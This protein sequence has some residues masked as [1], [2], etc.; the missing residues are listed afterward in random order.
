[1]MSDITNRLR[2]KYPLGP[3]GEDGEP[4]FGWRQFDRTTLP[5]IH[6]E[7][8]DEIDRLNRRIAEL[9]SNEARIKQDV[10]RYRW[11]RDGGFLLL[12]SGKGLGWP[13]A[14]E[15][16]TLVDEYIAKSRVLDELTEISQKLGL[17][18]TEDN[19]NEKG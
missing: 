8:A 14:Y 15:V 13:E 5:P 3:I 10:Y 12:D 6:G 16:D 4:E 1:M 7:A 19:T 17:Y 18:N 11:I 9:E 2:G